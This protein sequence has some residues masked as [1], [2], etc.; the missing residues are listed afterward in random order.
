ITRAVVIAEPCP[1][2]EQFALRGDGESRE[3]GKAVEK[4]LVVRD[5]GSDA[6]LLQHDLRNPDRVRVAR[7]APGEVAFRGSIPGQKKGLEFENL[8][9]LKHNES[10]SGSG[11]TPNLCILY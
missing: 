6:S 3:I 1:M 10:C 4:A 5:C 8:V 9:L 2:R 7:P 11:R